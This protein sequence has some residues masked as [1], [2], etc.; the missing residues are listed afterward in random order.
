MCGA[1]T[2]AIVLCLVLLV[3][4]GVLA[5]FAFVASAEKHRTVAGARV[6]ESRDD[7]GLTAFERLHLRKVITNDIADQADVELRALVMKTRAR[8]GLS[9]CIAGL[10]VVLLAFRTSAY[11]A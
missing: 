6:E 4:A 2:A 7:A 11:C 10:L 8:L 5:R 1:V 9:V 3:P